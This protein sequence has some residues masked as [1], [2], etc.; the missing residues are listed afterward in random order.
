MYAGTEHALTFHIFHD[1]LTV[2]WTPEAQAYI[3]SK[4]FAKIQMQCLGATNRGTRY[5]VI[6]ACQLQKNRK[7]FAVAKIQSIWRRAL[8]HKHIVVYFL[9]DGML[10]KVNV[11]PPGQK[12][13]LPDDG[14]PTF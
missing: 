14:S 2:W 9:L 4:G 10:I 12:D 6:F 8:A 7:A 3:A 1:G 11:R 13:A 5:E